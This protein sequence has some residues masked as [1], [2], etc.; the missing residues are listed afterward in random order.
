MFSSA[1]LTVLVSVGSCSVTWDD[2]N[3]LLDGEQLEKRDTQFVDSTS[4][5]TCPAGK[6]RPI[7]SDLFKSTFNNNYYTLVINV[8]FEVRMIKCNIGDPLKIQTVSHLVLHK[9]I[10][11]RFTRCTSP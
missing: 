3:R 7:L 11:A 5:V 2:L 4:P 8:T 6:G 9:G 1:L 10:V